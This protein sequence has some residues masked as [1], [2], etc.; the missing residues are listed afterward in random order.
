M[1][2]S[3]VSGIIVLLLL[4]GHAHAGPFF[5]SID[6]HEEP[7]VFNY[8]WA[9]MKL[10]LLLGTAI[11]GVQAIDQHE[12]LD[13]D[14]EAQRV[15]DGAL[16]G[17][18]GGT[19]LGLGIGFYG[20]SEGKTGVG[21]II[22]RDMWY[23]G[24][25][26]LIVGGAIGGLQY[27]QTNEWRH[28]N[29]SLVWGYIGGTIAGFAFGLIEGPQIASSPYDKWRGRFRFTLAPGTEGAPSPFLTYQ[30]KF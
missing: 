17:V 9:G 19:M 2:K 30:K 7:S 22:L 16:Y 8:G 13:D 15:L 23:G 29:E 27:S 18:I 14:E 5:G 10:G 21:G 12:R 11:G 28:F 26:G 4:V 1:I 25:I 3:C 24:G 20:L 6:P